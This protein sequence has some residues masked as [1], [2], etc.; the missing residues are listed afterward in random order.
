[1]FRWWADWIPTP[2]GQNWCA[3]KMREA[4][5]IVNGMI[6]KWGLDV[7]Q[8]GEGVVD[9]GGDPGFVAA[10]LIRSGIH[11]TVIDPGF[12][13]SG[14]SNP[15]TD[16][17]L[18]DPMHAKRM[19]EGVVPFR[20]IQHPFTEAFAK[21]PDNAS[22]LNGVSAFV[23]LYPDEATDFLLRFTAK[24]NLRT[25]LIPCNEC[26]RFFPPH[27][28]TYEG[29][30]KHL[31]ILDDGYVQESGG[32]AA[33]LQRVQIWGTPFCP[34]LLQRSP[35]DFPEPALPLQD[36]TAGTDCLPKKGK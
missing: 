33:S 11:V 36:D 23:S 18:R 6:Q 5:C 10:E 20:K 24:M 13:K 34:V 21:D 7:L 19:R 28:P 2:D 30:V 32:R 16:R 25:A 1:M 3:N 29:F 22:F 27:E 35:S 14:K 9:I 12:G 26:V 4:R 17:F 15:A 31:L 8:S